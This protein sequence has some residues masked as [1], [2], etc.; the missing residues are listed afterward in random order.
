MKICVPIAAGSVDAALRKM[1]RAFSVADVLELRIDRIGKA[2]LKR[3]LKQKP[4]R[5]LVTNRRREEGGGFDGSE[6]NR[7]AL[8][9]KA[10]SLGAG[11]VDIEAGTDP[12][13]IEDLR[14]AIRRGGGKTKLIVSRHDPGGTPG[15]RTLGKKLDECAGLGADIVKIVTAARTPDDSLRVL[16]LIARGRERGVDVIAFCMGEAG[17]MSRVMAPLLG[18]F[19]TFASLEKGEESAPGQFTAKEMRKI[20]KGFEVLRRAQDDD[21]VQGLGKFPTPAIK[22]RLR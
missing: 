16:S 1:K 19:L 3:L 22:Q 4:E 12:A 15:I 20:L 13:L 7:T 5:I 21:R 11:Y 18:A 14:E 10:V 2:D 9:E 6:K 8:L 17:R